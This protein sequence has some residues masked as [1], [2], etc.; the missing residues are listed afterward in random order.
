MEN[1]LHF[2]L[3]PLL[4]IMLGAVL[5][6]L[7]SLGGVLNVNVV[8]EKVSESSRQVAGYNYPLQNT[9]MLQKVLKT[10]SEDSAFDVKQ[11]NNL[12]FESLVHSN[13]RT[14][15]PFENWLLWFAGKFYEPFSRTQDPNRIVLGKGGLCSE[16]SAVFNHI[17]NINGLETRFVSLGGHVVSEVLTE[18]GWRIVDP[19]Y[20]VNYPVGLKGLE[21]AEGVVLMEEML[22]ERG[23]SK[24]VVKRYIEVFQTL[25]DNTVSESNVAISPRLYSVE[26][27]AEWLKWIFPA[28]FILLGLYLWKGSVFSLR[29]HNLS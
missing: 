22:N 27:V 18:G 2:K 5:I 13:N 10:K 17:A 7:N 23:Y 26:L 12:I 21:R 20:G 9:L 15:H 19:D 6:I 14:I 25:G 24:A 11:V 28:M 29:Q 3:L 1:K 4:L 16:V 8:N